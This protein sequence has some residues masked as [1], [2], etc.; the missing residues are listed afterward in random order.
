MGKR[1]GWLALHQIAVALSYLILYTCIRPL[2]DAHWQLT[3]G[4]R[5]GLLLLVPYRYWG[6]LVIADTITN[7]YQSYLNAAQFGVSWAVANTLPLIAFAMPVVWWCKERLTLFPSKRLVNFQTLLLCTLL[8]SVI[9]SLINYGAIVLAKNPGVEISPVLVVYLFFG[10]YAALLTT[11]PW[12]LVAKLEYRSGNLLSRLRGFIEGSVARD[13]AVFLI[14]MQIALLWLTVH[15]NENRQIYCLLM[16]IP[17]AWLTLKHGWR[18]VL[19]GT[20]LIACICLLMN[21]ETPD[22][23]VLQIQAVITFAVTCLIAMGAR[24]S[25][26]RQREER[27]LADAKQ[28]LQLARQNLHMS[29][30]R[31]R[32]ASEVLEYVC[33]EMHITQNHL[34]SRFRLM[35]PVNESQN[36]SKQAANT[37]EKLYQIADSM[38]PIAWRR[39][40]LPAALH[41]NLG[42]ALDEIGVSYSY[43][44]AG[45]GFGSHSIN[46]HSTI[47]RLACESLVYIC[48]HTRCSNIR[49]SLR[50]GQINDRRFAVLRIDGKLDPV[51][52][53]DA[54]FKA[55]QLDRLAQKLGATR[56]NLPELRDLAQIFNGMLHVR[57]KGDA[58]RLT[59]LLQD[60]S[61]NE[62]Q[63][64]SSASTSLQLWAN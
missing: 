3:A 42:R 31:L 9:W 58:M 48:T 62:D 38:H 17:V 16:F 59:F 63:E 47:Y 35:L 11:V 46:L 37:R 57:P 19:G 1:Q 49:L 40:G 5:L 39:K 18:A 60:V 30:M 32:Q 44:I 36:Y 20:I 10:S 61:S 56:L 23:A 15:S 52:E 55:G 43:H 54:F 24:I 51:A 45:R 25:A 41:E 12:V 34:L 4:L 28:A 2:S 33:G 29:E 53:D 6:A 64:P 7:A 22:P 8:V 27:S 13:L 50:G 14:P 26:M 21:Y